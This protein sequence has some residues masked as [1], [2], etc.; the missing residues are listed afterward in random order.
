MPIGRMLFLA[1]CLCSLHGNMQAA[2]MCGGQPLAEVRKVNAIPPALLTA[3]RFSP[4]GRDIAD[5]GE[6]FNSS[7]IPQFQ[8]PQ[9]RLAVAGVGK[10]CA[11]VVIEQGGVVHFTELFGLRLH[12]D[13]WLVERRSRLDALP[14]SLRE[15]A[16]LP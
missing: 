8:L 6:P 13:V 9:R 3:M 1:A 5:A 14:G 7:D 15:L 16:L 11:V 12:G 2:A 4:S 10:T